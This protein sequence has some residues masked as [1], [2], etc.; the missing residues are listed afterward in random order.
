M[1]DIEFIPKIPL[2][3]LGKCESYIESKSTK[4]TCK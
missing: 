4:Q 1:I 3:N 2:G